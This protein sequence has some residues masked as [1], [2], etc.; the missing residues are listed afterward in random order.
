MI[1]LMRFF[2][3]IIID[4]KT[5]LTHEWLRGCETNTCGC[6]EK[7]CWVILLRD[8]KIAGKKTTIFSQIMF[9]WFKFRF[10]LIV[11]FPWRTRTSRAVDPYPKTQKMSATCLDVD[12]QVL[13]KINEVPKAAIVR[14]SIEKRTSRKSDAQNSLSVLIGSISHVEFSEEHLSRQTATNFFYQ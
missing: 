7:G 3:R 13:G 14:Q 2:G 4:K 11:F 6:S 5:T 1:L 8:M 12:G 10:F 9:R